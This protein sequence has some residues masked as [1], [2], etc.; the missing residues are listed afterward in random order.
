MNRQEIVILTEV[1]NS[2]FN[3]DPDTGKQRVD[4]EGYGIVTDIC[5][6]RMIR[7]TLI[8]MGH[9]IMMTRG[10]N[11][12]DKYDG[13][14]D[15]QLIE[16]YIDVRLFGGV[17]TGRNGTKDPVVKKKCIPGGEENSQLRGPVQ[18]AFGKSIAP[19]DCQEI[20]IAPTFSREEGKTRT[21]GTKYITPH[22]VFRQH[23]YIS[24]GLAE[25]MG[26]TEADI[27]LMLQTI[28]HMYENCRSTARMDLRLRGLYVITHSTK[29]GSM[30]AH[31]AL[32]LISV[33]ANQMKPS[34]WADYQ[35]AINGLE[36]PAGE[37]VNYQDLCTI[38]RVV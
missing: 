4:D 26:T 17:I 27:E 15:Q 33:N 8:E 2:S 6:K 28:P 30:P 1:V 22:A 36:L 20:Q 16:E 24:A 9:E 35:V 21:L 37:S 23:M 3:G 11:L 13:K 5:L 34:S 32:D 14:T 7:E 19:I 29:Y 10:C 12:H 38:R 31:Q 25:K 18:V